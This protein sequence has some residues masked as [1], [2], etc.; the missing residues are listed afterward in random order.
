MGG[1]IVELNT[2]TL[3]VSNILSVGSLNIWQGVVL[4][5]NGNIVMVPQTSPNILV[6]NNQI[7]PGTISNVPYS[8]A[9]NFIGGVL[10]PNG[11]VAM[12]PVS[13]ANVCIFN[14][15]PP[16]SFSNIASGGTRFQGGV[17]LPNGNIICVPNSSSSNIGMI[18]PYALT[19]SNSTPVGINPFNGGVL[20]P[21]GQVI[22]AAENGG[23]GVGVLNTM[24]PVDPAFCLSPFFNKY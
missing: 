2:T 23:S 18:D 13:S 14:P 19:F 8:S 15:N 4:L 9:P 22:L 16:F 20:L 10:T 1:N 21:N 7:T 17:L 3:A 12:I 6:Y 5:P 24:V 11:N